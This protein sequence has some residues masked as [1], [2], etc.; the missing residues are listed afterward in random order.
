[1]S[2]DPQTAGR[3]HPSPEGDGARSREPIRT[4]LW[5]AATIRPLDEV[6]ALVGLLRRT[7]EV[8]SPADEALKAAA[9]ARP[10]D[11]VR[12]LVLMLN[13]PPQQ[14]EE[15][16]T[17]LRAAAVGRPIEDVVQLVSILGTDG[18]RGA[19][20]DEARWAGAERERAAGARTPAVSVARE[21]TPDPDSAPEPVGASLAEPVAEPVV[22]SVAET[23]VTAVTARIA[24]PVNESGPAVGDASAAAGQQKAVR[25]SETRPRG[26]TFRC[27]PPTVAQHPAPQ[28]PL[29]LRRPARPGPRHAVK[30]VELRSA[31]PAVNPPQAL[32]SVLRW[33]AGAALIVMG[34]VNLPKN[35]TELRS[36]GHSDALSLVITVLCLVLAVWLMVQDMVWTWTASAVVAAGV[37]V[38]HSMA[39][40]GS[41][42]LPADSLGGS[43]MWARTVALC[44]AI[45]ALALCGNALMRRRAADVAGDVQS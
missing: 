39:G 36:G 33:P 8:P 21:T 32:R 26:S 42:S 20:A 28:T 12:Q 27:V 3:E 22:E 15:A 23:V 17:T 5:T 9:V 43:H 41:I 6:A 29:S 25:V 4:L 14:P 2:L 24:E 35:L 45:A 7:G 13:S 38:I 1:M 44:C 37:L 10:L 16:D 19:E 18:N 34:L 40:F 30:A 11:E 31:E